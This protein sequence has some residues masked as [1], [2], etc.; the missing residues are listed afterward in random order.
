MVFLQT[1]L[2]GVNSIE[3]Q[4]TQA[5]RQKLDFGR[6]ITSIAGDPG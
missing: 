1:L 5:T 2:I 3:R 6:R 4:W